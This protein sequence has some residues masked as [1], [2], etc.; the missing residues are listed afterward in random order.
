METIPSFIKKYFTD[1]EITKLQKKEALHINQFKDIL[2][3]RLTHDYK[4]YPRG[5]VFYEG[6]LI[7]GYPR[8]MRVLHLENG[9]KRYFKERFY[10]ESIG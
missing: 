9:I 10:I 8:I 4:N 6:G 1:T 5:T 7:P 3:V 2:L